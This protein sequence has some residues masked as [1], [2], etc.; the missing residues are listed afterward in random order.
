MALAMAAPDRVPVAPSFLT[1]AIRQAGVRQYDYHT[2]PEV[3]AAAQIDHCERYDFDGAY[4]S[5][6]NVVLYEAL[7]GRIVYPD[8][9][10]YP[11]WTD[12]L[13]G[14]SHD[15]ARLHVPDPERDGRLPVLIEAACIA[16]ERA[17]A[18]RFVL[19]NIDSGPLQLALTLM[20]MERG[21]TYLAQEP[22]RM[23]EILEF[24]AQVTIAYGVGMAR[25]GCHGL[26]FGESSAPLVGPERYQDIV[27]PYDCEVIRELKK[28]GPHVFLHVCGDSR[29]IFD[30]MVASGADCLEFD[31]QV[32]MAWAKERARGRVTLKGNISTGL[33]LSLTPEEMAQEC[34]GIIE[35]G[36][37]GGGLI[38][39][40][41]CE[42]PA[43]TPDE[44]L[45]AV[46]RSVDVARKR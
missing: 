34:Q 43:D 40:G 38:L 39:A 4:I 41:G 45:V 23:R 42:V 17:G 12:P 9:H 31:S 44:V 3:L 11:F 22:A 32:D 18:R 21:M 27:W 2:R 33:F 15:L 29:G 7:G 46:R 14:G 28:L 16:M 24:C 19:A 10:S 13:L 1:R 5:S 36:G 37:C 35:S 6:D 20:G 25:S 8:E 30:L 26:Q